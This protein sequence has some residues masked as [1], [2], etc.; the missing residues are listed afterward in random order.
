MQDLLDSILIALCLGALILFPILTRIWPQSYLRRILKRNIHRIIPSFLKGSGMPNESN[1]WGN[2]SILNVLASQQTSRASELYG[3]I[4]DSIRRSLFDQADVLRQQQE[5]ALAMAQ[6]GQNMNAVRAFG[7][8]LQYQNQHTQVR[9]TGAYHPVTGTIDHIAANYWRQVMPVTARADAL[10]G[11]LPRKILTGFRGF[12]FTARLVCIANNTASYQLIDQP[13]AGSVVMLD[14]MDMEEGGDA[15]RFVN[16]GVSQALAQEWEQYANTWRIT[17]VGPARIT[18]EDQAFAQEQAR[19]EQAP[20]DERVG[21][22][23][24]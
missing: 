16:S 19:F 23:G 1:N 6:L 20:A 22:L 3:D 10:M 21:L 2:D 17:S 7:M 13:F 4:Q 15:F 12:E 8:P 5:D 14:L 24:P 18:A 9:I 11:V